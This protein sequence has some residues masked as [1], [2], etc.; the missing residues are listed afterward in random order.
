MVNLVPN[1]VDAF[2]KSATEITSGI[3]KNVPI[4][5]NATI[6]ADSLIL[7]AVHV[8]IYIARQI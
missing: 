4:V 8:L 7:Q 6:Y 5:G 1:A 3:S 2:A